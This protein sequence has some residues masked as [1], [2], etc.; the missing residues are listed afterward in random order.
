MLS[1]LYFLL[2]VAATIVMSILAFTAHRQLQ[3]VGFSPAQI[4]DNF[5]YWDNIGWQ[6]LWLSS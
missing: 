1:K 6:F 4:A 3:S 5:R 2:F